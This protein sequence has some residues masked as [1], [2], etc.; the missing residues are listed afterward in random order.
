[1][2]ATLVFC[3]YSAFNGYPLENLSV[4]YYY[5]YLDTLKIGLK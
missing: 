4:F 3:C 1:M 5:L 2:I